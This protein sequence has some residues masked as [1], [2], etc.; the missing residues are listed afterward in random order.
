MSN[1]ILIYLSPICRFGNCEMDDVA[2]IPKDEILCRLRGYPV[3]DTMLSTSRRKYFYLKDREI[4][5][6]DDALLNN[7]V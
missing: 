1:L 4:K 5:D 3:V 7:L 2:R 6:I